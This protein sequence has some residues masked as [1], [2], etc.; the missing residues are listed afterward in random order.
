[1]YLLLKK[2]KD[3]GFTLIELLVVVAIIGLL[4]SI[5][6]V[7]LNSARAKARTTRS[8]EDLNSLRTALE[9]YYSD[10][11]FYPASSAG[12]DGLYSCWGDSTPDWIHG[13]TPNYISA[14]PRSPN[15]STDCSDNYLY[16]SNQLDYKLLWHVPEDCN[17]VRTKYPNLIDPE[18]NDPLGDCWAYGF[19]TPGAELF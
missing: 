17:G 2:K 10:H 19:W 15:N 13:L 7:S 4:A 9:L 16:R 14:L 8:I 11:G 6:M 5:T 18:R 3:K 12:W 1:M